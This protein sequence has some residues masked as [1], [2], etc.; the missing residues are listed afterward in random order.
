[1]NSNTTVTPKIGHYL[2]TVVDHRF[3]LQTRFVG[4]DRRCSCGGNAKRPCRHIEAVSSHLRK[5]GERAPEERP[6]LRLREKRDDT[7]TSGTPLACAICGTPVEK[8]GFDFWKCPKDSVHYWQ[9]RG[10]QCGIK[11]FLTKPHPAKQGAFYSMSREERKIFLAQATRRFR[12]GGY[13]PYP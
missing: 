10:E 4:K 6:A 8:L 5:G 12:A 13:T 3:G 2:V 11:D 1:M 7:P 9:W